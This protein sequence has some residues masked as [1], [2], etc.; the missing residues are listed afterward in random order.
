MN[1][2]HEKHKFFIEEIKQ[3][4]SDGTLG[5]MYLGT[6]NHSRKIKISGDMQELTAIA[7]VII[8]ALNSRKPLCQ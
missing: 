5:S 3:P 6:R 7:L 4:K 8:P 2:L 1:T